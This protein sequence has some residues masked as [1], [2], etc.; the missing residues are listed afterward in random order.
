MTLCMMGMRGKAVCRRRVRGEGPGCL[1]VSVLLGI[2]TQ[3]I[4]DGASRSAAT[5]CGI[6]GRDR[7]ECECEARE[8]RSA[9]FCSGFIG[10]CGDSSLQHTL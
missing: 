10:E 9:G 3:L 8:G 1:A 4:A 6:A 7:W 2:R 5:R